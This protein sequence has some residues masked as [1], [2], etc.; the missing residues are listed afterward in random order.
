MPVTKNA[1]LRYGVIDEALS[2]GA[3]NR[4]YALNKRELLDKVNEALDQH[5]VEP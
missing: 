4:E 5:G 2:K 3:Q 1:M